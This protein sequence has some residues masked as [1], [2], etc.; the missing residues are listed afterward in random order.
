MECQS[1]AATGRV[2]LWLQLQSTQRGFNPVV[3][4]IILSLD[5]CSGLHRASSGDQSCPQNLA[6][7]KVE[8]DHF[9]K[10]IMCHCLFATTKH[11]T[12]KLRR[13]LPVLCCCVA[14]WKKSCWFPCPQHLSYTNPSEILQKVSVGAQGSRDTKA[15]SPFLTHIY[16][17][18]FPIL[19][20]FF[21]SEENNWDHKRVRCYIIFHKYTSLHLLSIVLLKH[22]QS[23]WQSSRQETKSQ[24]SRPARATLTAPNLDPGSKNMS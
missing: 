11:R 7:F 20:F 3:S 18:Q 22:M 17:S 2:P 23:S 21:R 13:C 24:R 4:S 14:N 8:H 16:F 12:Q 1:H 9:I 5:I 19:L 6:A 15:L 10:G